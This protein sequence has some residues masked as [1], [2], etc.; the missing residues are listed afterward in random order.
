M[1]RVGPTNTS[2]SESPEQSCCR[3]HHRSAATR[4]EERAAQPCTGPGSQRWPEAGK[5]QGHPITPRLLGSRTS[6]SEEGNGEAGPR[7][8]GATWAGGQAMPHPSQEAVGRPV[9]RW[10]GSQRADNCDHRP[11]I[12]LATRVGKRE[13][14]LS[15]LTKKRRSLFRLEEFLPVPKRARCWNR[16]GASR[17]QPRGC[18][19]LQ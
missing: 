16:R 7:A 6:H 13:I 11:G 12:L 10:A 17:G 18:M 14:R 3:P 2:V 15:S 9:G 1:L 19:L 8:S 4:E 5:A